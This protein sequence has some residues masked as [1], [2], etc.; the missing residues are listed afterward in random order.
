MRVKLQIEKVEFNPSVSCLR[1]TW[2]AK[3]QT[4]IGLCLHRLN[5]LPAETFITQKESTDFF[6][7]YGI[8]L[9]SKS[10]ASF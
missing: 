10:V 2:H 8:C 4:S 1:I 6:H 7:L 5:N 3:D 9:I